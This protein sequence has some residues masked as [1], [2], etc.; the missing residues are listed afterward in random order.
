MHA[1]RLYAGSQRNRRE[2]LAYSWAVM[3]GLVSLPQVVA[4]GLFMYP[5][6]RAGEFGGEF[7]LGPAAALP[8][9]AASPRSHVAGKYWLVNTA[10]EPLALHMVCPHRGCLYK[11]VAANYRFA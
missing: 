1:F 10:Q 9:S 5:R 2:F 8:A 6:F 4:T 7:P 3:V 11:W